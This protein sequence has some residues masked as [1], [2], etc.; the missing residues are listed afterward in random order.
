MGGS[1]RDFEN[2][3]SDSE[4]NHA[5]SES[6]LRLWISAL[7]FCRRECRRR[8]SSRGARERSPGACHSNRL[9][10]DTWHGYEMLFGL[11][12]VVVSGFLLTAVPSWTGERGFA[13]WRLVLQTHR[14]YSEKL[15]RRQS[16][17]E[18]FTPRNASCL[19]YS[20]V[21]LEPAAEDLRAVRSEPAD[22]R[23]G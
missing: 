3:R 20:A 15:T 8:F 5:L 10:A 18:A 1:A 16:F 23:I 7:L 14:G 17:G 11:L 22:L 12:V 19:S 6:P 13:G 21:E 4:S 2:A 9:A